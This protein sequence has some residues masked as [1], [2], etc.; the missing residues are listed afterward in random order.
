MSVTRQSLLLRAQEG[1]EGAWKDLTE[2]YRPLIAG[3]LR[4]Q[5]VPANELD[6]LVQEILLAVVQ[7]L[8]SFRHSG[9]TGAFRAW[10]RAIAHNYTC[11]FW[12]ARA[13]K[14]RATGDSTVAEALRQLEDPASALNRQ[15][16]EEHDRYVLRCLL[17]QMELEFEPTTIQAFRRLTLDGASGAAVAAELGLTVGTVYSAK[18][19]VLQRLRQ[20][21]EG[22]ID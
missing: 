2:L 13:H 15:W 16:E 4:R 8:P 19:R 1:D 6:D 22:L 12:K 18:S 10:L 17:D 21:A 11:D 7:S 14:A 5:A 9:R 20:E 3:W